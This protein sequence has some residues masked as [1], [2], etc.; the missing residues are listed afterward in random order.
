MVPP[1][2]FPAETPV[3]NITDGERGVILNGTVIDPKSGEWVEFEV[4]TQY[5]IERWEREDFILF[6]EFE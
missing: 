4:A 3:L 5:G 1:G 2:D 6:R